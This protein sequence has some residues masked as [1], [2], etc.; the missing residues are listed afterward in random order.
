[1]RMCQ[2][3]LRR[4]DSVEEATV[5]LVFGK[6]CVT[7]LSQLLLKLR[8]DRFPRN[9]R[10]SFAGLRALTAFRNVGTGLAG[11]FLMF[12][13]R[14][15]GYPPPVKRRLQRPIHF[16][17]VTWDNRASLILRCGTGHSTGPT[18]A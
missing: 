10:H 7:L 9:D 3:S 2:E 17:I 6:P 8:A 14:K 11:N 4:F 1:M 5:V 16:F 18:F 12:L 13:K 15:A